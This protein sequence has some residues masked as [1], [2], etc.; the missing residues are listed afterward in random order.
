M[1]VTA[2]VGQPF[3]SIAEGA[4]PGLVGTI[5]VQLLDIYGNVVIS[6]TTAGISELAPG[7][8]EWQCAS[9]PQYAGQYT[10]LWDD[11]SDHFATDDLEVSPLVQ[12]PYNAPPTTGIWPDLSGFVASRD[13]LYANFGITMAFLIPQE[14]AYDNTMPLG[15]FGEPLDPWATPASGGIDHYASAFA[16]GLLVTRPYGGRGQVRDQQSQTPIGVAPEEELGVN[17]R[18]ADY[19]VFGPGGSSGEATHVEFWG[20]IYQIR[21]WRPDGIGGLQRYVVYITQESNAT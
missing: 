7:V 11:G 3:I 16:S 10:I 15:P 14:T 6:R 20:Q 18:P 2:T 13:V 4:T 1:S 17:I 5:G 8:Y 21:Q 9:A 19:A 12:I